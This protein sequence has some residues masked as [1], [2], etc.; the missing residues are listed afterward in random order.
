[1]AVEIT[2]YSKAGCCLCERVQEQLAV[3]SQSTPLAVTEIDITSDAAL[4]KAMFDRIPVVHIGPV[5]LQ[6]PIDPDDLRR[7]VHQAARLG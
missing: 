1:M 7:A 5:V 3:L 2:F 6:A 4:E